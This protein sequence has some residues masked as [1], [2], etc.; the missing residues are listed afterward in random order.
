MGVKPSLKLLLIVL[1][2]LS[3]GNLSSFRA[4]SAFLQPLD[5]QGP[6]VLIVGSG[7]SGLGAAQKLHSHGFRNVKILEATGRSGGRIWSQRYGKGLVEIGAQWIHGPSPENPT[8][9][10]ASQYDLLGP[11]ALRK[12]NQQIEIEGYPSFSVSY[13][14]LGKPINP[15]VME[16][17]TEM[18]S[19]WL[20]KSKQFVQGEVDIKDSVGGFLRQ[21]IERIFQK[22]D[23]E[24]V[25]QKMAI[26]NT[27]LKLECCI[28]GTHSMDYVSLGS[29]GEYK[30]L[31]GLDC[32]FPGGYESLISRMKSSLPNNT[33]MLNKAVKTINWKGSFQ[34]SD[35]CMYPVQ[36]ECEDGDVFVADHVIVTVP[37][38]FLKKQARDF[39]H[40]PLPSHKLEA[41]QNMG[42]GTNN[43]IML[44]FD[45]PF[46]D[47]ECKSI[48]LVWEGES[49]LAAPQIN[50]QKEWVK[51]LAGFVVL[52]PPEQLG[53]VL[54]G[55]IAGEESEFM[56]TLTDDEILTTMTALLRQFTGNPELPAPISVLRSRWHSQPYTRG[57]YSYVAV[58]SSGEDVDILAQPLP[59]EGDLAKP[60]QVLFAGEATH[61]IFYSTTHGALMSGRREAE[62]LIAHYPALHPSLSRSSL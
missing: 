60:L 26:V 9:E 48:Q 61:R 27:L 24:S 11:E 29:F 20:N 1:L 39:L 34:G 10:L 44:E 57:S 56:E 28:S 33:V 30:M 52:Q 16:S 41:I 22:W 46:W 47:P 5:P 8:F 6:A 35:S 21:E 18:F 54:S 14:S 59:E 3:L 17:V 19:S 13:S 45:E 40:P 2:V 23:R 36:V 49:P 62:R 32:T 15:E 4:A 53:H 50:L 31:P 43:K 38:G 25:E 42:F 7:I 58:G 55:F 37:L 12:E 51:K